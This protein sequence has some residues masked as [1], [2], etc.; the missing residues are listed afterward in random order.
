MR[1]ADRLA[2]V[3]GQPEKADV[4]SVVTVSGKESSVRPAPS[5][6]LSPME[7]RP[8]GKDRLCRLEQL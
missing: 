5:K 2:W 6:A 4:P 1:P 3:I 8:L 7:V